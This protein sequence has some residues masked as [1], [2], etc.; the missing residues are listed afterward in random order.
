MIAN[1][2]TRTTF[3][4]SV[5]NTIQ[6]YGL[7]GIDIDFEYPGAVERD[8]PATDTP[9]LTAF[10]EQVKSTLP[11]TTIISIAT[12]AGYWFLK[13]F[14][15]DKISSYVT[16]MNMMYY[17]GPWDTN[18]TDQAP[19]TNPQT[20]IVDITTSALLYTRAGIDLSIVNLGLAWYGRTFH[21]SDTSC[22]GYNCTM[23]GGGAPG[24]CTAASGILAMFEIQEMIANGNTPIYDSG[25]QT[26]WFDDS[27]G[28][29]VTFDQADTWQDK[30]T[31]ADQT[32]FGGTFIWSVDQIIPG[33][34]GSTSL[35][36]GAGSLGSYTAIEWNPNPYPAS[37][38]QSE[39]FVGFGSTVVIPIPS[40]TTQIILGTDTI[41]VGVG[42]TPVGSIPPTGVSLLNA[43]TPTWTYNIIPPTSAATVTFTAPIGSPASY[44]SAVAAPTSPGDP[45][46][47]VSGPNGD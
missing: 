6:E 8:A 24:V 11:D 12:P 4:S 44:I 3:I 19:V 42:G 26:Y 43:I 41:S 9:N 34:N 30:V 21:L 36:G 33:Y 31:F 38:V 14:E 18:V 32:C 13:G 16:Y 22:Q 5:Q 46:Q 45:A 27:N 7:D 10:F 29:L 2:S 25:S 28:D 39:T 35:G 17:H 23:V 40:S 15:I 1:A 47:T 37:N 20:S